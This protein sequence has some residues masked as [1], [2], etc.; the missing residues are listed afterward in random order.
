MANAETVSHTGPDG[1]PLVTRIEGAGVPF[2]VMVGETLA[3]GSLG[4]EPASVVQAWMDSP[5]HRER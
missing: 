4:W 2:T 3:M 1:S 5:A